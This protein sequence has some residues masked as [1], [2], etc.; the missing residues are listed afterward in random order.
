[1][2]SDRSDVVRRYEDV[3]E[4]YTEI[5]LDESTAQRYFDLRVS[6]LCDQRGRLTGRLIVLR[7][8]ELPDCPRRFQKET[9]R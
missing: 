4:L 9:S 5:A 1:M 8:M 6:S 2:L 7:R 3:T